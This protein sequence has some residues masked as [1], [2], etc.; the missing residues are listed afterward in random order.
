MCSR[1]WSTDPRHAGQVEL[2]LKL[3]LGLV[4]AA[5]RASLPKTLPT[6]FM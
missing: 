5:R 1:F 3:A 4:G 2:G 6:K